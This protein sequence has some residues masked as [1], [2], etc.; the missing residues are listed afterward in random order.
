[1]IGS[2]VAT[3]ASFGTISQILVTGSVLPPGGSVAISL[4]VGG[5]TGGRLTVALYRSGVS[6]QQIYK[7]VP[8]DGT[9]TLSATADAE[10]DTILFEGF[11]AVGLTIDN[12]S[13][14]A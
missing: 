11:N 1:M 7:A 13:V 6:V 4:V 10:W 3:N 2:G 8:A 14:I 12:I 9:L 5:V